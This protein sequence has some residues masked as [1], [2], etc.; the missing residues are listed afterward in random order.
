MELAIKQKHR[1]SEVFLSLQGEGLH[2][3]TPSI[4][5]RYVGCTLRCPGFSRPKAERNL[6]NEEVKKVISEIGRYK[7]LEDL[8][9]VKTGCDSYPS[10]YP[11]FR[12]LCHSYTTDELI[13]K[14]DNL[15]AGLDQ[16]KIDLVFTGGEPLLH[17]EAIVDL[18]LTLKIKNYKFTNITFETNGT[19][20]LKNSFIDSLRLAYSVT[21]SV[22]PKLSLS[23]E[24]LQKRFNLEAIESLVDFC[25]LT[26]NTIYFKFVVAEEDDV[27]EVNDL[28]K[29]IQEYTDT[30]N[31][32]VYLMP[33]GGV[34]SESTHLT[35]KQ[36]ADLC[37][38]YGYR[39][40]LRTHLYIYGNAWNT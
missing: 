1:V 5:I 7:K 36:V 28:M 26:K 27:K 22:S 30:Y 21:I 29:K 18:L 38:K 6:P 9:L 12:H 11:E 19:V 2:T 24:P 23:G 3:G 14:I 25:F 16:S 31:F 34:K 32:L 37:I 4:F 20:A 33:V 40:C 35:E 39:M 10:V 8:P 13:E 17:Q 15:T